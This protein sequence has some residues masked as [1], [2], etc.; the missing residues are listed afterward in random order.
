MP[1][2][3]HW[4]IQPFIKWVLWGRH[5]LGVRNTVG[6]KAG[7]N[8]L[9][10]RYWYFSGWGGRYPRTVYKQISK[11]KFVRW[12]KALIEKIQPGHTH[13]E[14]RIGLG[15]RSEKNYNIKYKGHGDCHLEMI[16]EEKFEVKEWVIPLSGVRTYKEERRG[17]AKWLT[18]LFNS[19]AF[20]RRAWI[21]VFF[22]F[23]NSVDIHLTL[24]LHR[25]ITIRKI[26]LMFHVVLLLPLK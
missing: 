2:L 17:N 4:F 14:C 9:S 20:R 8:Y 19:F 26:Y 25:T 13:R 7:N 1:V 22:S 3:I 5:D 12:W 10:W 16:D 24:P 11:I 23:F 6:H 18:I 21:F 15:G